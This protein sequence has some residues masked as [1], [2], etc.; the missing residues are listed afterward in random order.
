MD[1]AKNLHQRICSKNQRNQ[2]SNQ[3]QTRKRNQVDNQ[4]ITEKPEKGLDE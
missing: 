4:V 3:K 2:Q 1:L